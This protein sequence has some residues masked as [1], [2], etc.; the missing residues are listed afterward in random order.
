MEKLDLSKILSSLNLSEF[1]GSWVM[2]VFI[3][4]LAVLLFSFGFN[5]FLHRLASRAEKS[6]NPWDDALI[7]AVQKPLQI[8]IW[9]VG[10]LFAADIVASRTEAEIFTAIGPLRHVGVVTTLAWF[11]IRFVKEFEKALI[12]RRYQIGQPIDVTTTHAIAKLVRA[13][14]FITAGIGD[15]ADPRL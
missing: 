1:I 8:L 9:V 11:L 14:V 2:Q 3:V 7:A 10:I 6:H 12:K 13:S 15:D 5:L 4:V